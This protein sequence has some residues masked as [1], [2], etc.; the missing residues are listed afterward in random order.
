MLGFWDVQGHVRA[1]APVK[2]G[3]Q[4]GCTTGRIQALMRDRGPWCMP[5]FEGQLLR[6]FLFEKGVSWDRAAVL[7]VVHAFEVHALMCV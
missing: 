6:C 5:L 3:M 1:E 2:E 7:P 4:D